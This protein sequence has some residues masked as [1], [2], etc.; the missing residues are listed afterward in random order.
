MVKKYIKVSKHTPSQLLSNSLHKKLTIMAK[1]IRDLEAE[2]RN[3]RIAFRDSLGDE[4]GDVSLKVLSTQADVLKLWINEFEIA[5]FTEAKRKPTNAEQILSEG[6][7]VAEDAW[8]CCELFW[9]AGIDAG[10]PPPTL[11]RW[12][13]AILPS[14]VV[15]AEVKAELLIELTKLLAKFR[16]YR[17]SVMKI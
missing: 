2:L 16:D 4:R 3:I 7:K 6:H 15:F 17:R 5:Y 12:E 1:S 10:G 11:T 13:A 8:F 9:N 14:G